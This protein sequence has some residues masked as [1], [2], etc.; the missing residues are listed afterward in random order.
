MTKATRSSWCLLLVAG[1]VVAAADP[2]QPP[3]HPNCQQVANADHD[4]RVQMIKH[5]ILSKL[6]LQHA[7]RP[8]LTLAALPRPLA[9]IYGDMHENSFEEYYGKTDR[10]ILFP[11]AGLEKCSPSDATASCFTY[12]LPKNLADEGSI[13][14][15]EFYLNRHTFRGVN[16]HVE[17]LI[18]VW[19]ANASSDRLEI[20]EM[21]ASTWS[22]LKEN[23]IKLEI[24]KSWV[25][26]SVSRQKLKVECTTCTRKSHIRK[27]QL[28][29]LAINTRSTPAP[30]RLR[31]SVDCAPGLKECC[32]DSLTIKFSDIG[33][34]KWVLQP[35]SYDAFFCRGSCSTVA[36]VAHSGSVHSTLIQRAASSSLAKDKV[37]LA[38]CCT[39]TKMASLQM[40]YVGEDNAVILKTLPNMIVESCGCL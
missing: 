21:I 12:T 10:V 24:S 40:L 6:R 5:S 36:S 32:R 13:E 17:H 18:N 2:T 29:F 19:A 7:P 25:N 16:R 35:T 9:S 31:R 39:P 34:D 15:A 28:P 20:V 3:C 14:S 8:N 11:D 38:P 22:K 1:L 26:S 33:W 4:A 27:D 23:W 30:Q 37:D